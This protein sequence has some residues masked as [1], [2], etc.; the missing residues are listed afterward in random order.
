MTRRRSLLT[1][2]AHGA[3]AGLAGTAALNAVSYLDMAVRA[4]PASQTPEQ[5]VEE[6]S[7]RAGIEIAGTP[8]ER[9]HRI[10][11]LAPLL[12]TAAGVATGV[13]IGALR[14]RG[15]AG[16]RGRL[17]ALSFGIVMLAGNAPMTLLKITDPRSWSAS[18]WAADVVPHV[19]YAV[20]AAAVVDG[21]A[22]SS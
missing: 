13:V 12:G 11:G 22:P 4:R 15:V 20:V 1:G 9:S 14:S 16:S 5:S 21:L 8:E 17:A 18:D 3:A 10:A 2:A 6:L 7:R 19:A